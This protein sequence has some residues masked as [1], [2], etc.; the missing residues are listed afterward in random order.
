MFYLK[1]YQKL[2]HLLAQLVER[3]AYVQRLCPRCGSPGVSP[4]LWPF[5]VCHS[6]CFLSI[7]SCSIN[8][9][10]KKN[11]FLIPDRVSVILLQL[12]LRYYFPITVIT[13]LHYYN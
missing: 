11:F 7:L 6:P 3:A 4:G 10:N 12:L 1:K 9:A 13:S 5:A 8:K 2:G